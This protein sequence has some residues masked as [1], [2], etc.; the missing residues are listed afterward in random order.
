VKTEAVE[1]L[2]RTLDPARA[3]DTPI[4]IGTAT[5]PYQPAERRFGLTRRL[6]ETLLLHRGLT[7]GLITKSTLVARDR[8]LLA[9]LAERHTLTVHLSLATTDAALLRRLEPRSPLPHARVRALRALTTA[10]VPAGVMIAPVLP[11]LTDSWA[12]LAAVMEAAKGA[13]ARF[14]SWA[15]LRL[16]PA[17]RARFL[18][19]LRREFPELAARYERHYADRTNT[20]RAYQRALG[21]RLRL[22]KEAF[23]FRKE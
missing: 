9:R 19:V 2:R 5:D 10:G 4:V 12:S 17:A 13:G 22:L 21:R 15:A 7:I 14:V 23:G 6:L 3:R 11:G 1:V 16:G 20:S 18:P 8:S